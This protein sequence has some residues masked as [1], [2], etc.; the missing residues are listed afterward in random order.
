MGQP[1]FSFPFLNIKQFGAWCKLLKVIWRKSV[2]VAERK[3]FWQNYSLFTPLAFI[4]SH[5]SKFE[6]LG[7]YG[8]HACIGT[9][10]RTAAEFIYL[11]GAI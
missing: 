11:V 4:L 1:F 9:I 8:F 7:I 6:N 5:F 2:K 10:D 3:S